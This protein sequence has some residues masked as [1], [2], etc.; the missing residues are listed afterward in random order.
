MFISN[1]DNADKVDCSVLKDLFND[2]LETTNTPT[3]G[4][5]LTYLYALDVETAAEIYVD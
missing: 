1:D 4:D 5:F 2:Y 3:S